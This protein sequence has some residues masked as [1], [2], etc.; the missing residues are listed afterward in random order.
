MS[1]L[2]QELIDVVLNFVGDDDRTLRACSLVSS[3]FRT[4]SQK[5]LFH[6][7]D[8]YLDRA[9]GAANA[10]LHFLLHSN[11]RFRV[12]IQTV[13]IG[14]YGGHGDGTVAEILGMLPRVRSLSLHNAGIRPTR[15]LSLSET[16]RSPLLRMMQSSILVDLS[17]EYVDI[18]FIHLR[19]LPQLKHLSMPIVHALGNRI[20]A[21]A[22]AGRSDIPLILPPSA[23]GYL[24]ALKVYNSYECERL[25]DSLHKPGS[26]LLLTRLS[27]FH[28]RIVTI[29][30][31]APF[32]GILDI[33]SQ[34]LLSLVI[35][36]DCN[37]NSSGNVDLRTLS[38]LR[39]LELHLSGRYA[40]ICGQNLLQVL[41]MLPPFAP[42]EKLTLLGVSEF[43]LNSQD[44]YLLDDIL[45]SGA[46][47][48]PPRFVVI[49]LYTR[50]SYVARHVPKLVQ[51][52]SIRIID[53]F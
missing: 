1:T 25:I 51:K 34:T 17:L 30:D 20:G 35:R 32:Q 22:M 16:F 7:V 33:A 52:N 15:W 13:A 40:D 48:P 53:R 31:L 9:H 37:E 29:G 10:R 44:W 23:P 49:E 39:Y 5:H 42:L 3:S 36:M 47:I 8:I 18:P 2:P 12:Y 24:E 38:S 4:T 21:H 41:Q 28:G 14:I 11:P 19:C 6:S 27:T 43:D 50:Q 26:G 46:S 45:T